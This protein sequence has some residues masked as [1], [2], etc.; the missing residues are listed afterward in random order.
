M[1]KYLFS[2]IL[3]LGLLANAN[4]LSFSASKD[5]VIE[6]CEEAFSILEN[7]NPPYLYAKALQYIADN[8]C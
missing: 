5:V 1:K 4:N 7:P 8:D 3:F 6:S 2:A